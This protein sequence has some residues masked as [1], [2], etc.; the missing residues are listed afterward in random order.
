MALCRGTTSGH[1][2]LLVP[3]NGKGRA[4]PATQPVGTVTA[5]DR[6]ALTN[7]AQVVDDCGFRMLE[8]HELAAAMA[9]PAGYIPSGLTK[10]DRVRLAGNAVTPPVMT[11]IVG[12]VAQA[13]EGA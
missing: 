4:Q 5:A 7:A 12:R 10:R 9:F 13:L 2:S 3:Y 8:P 1:Q 11:W 6:W